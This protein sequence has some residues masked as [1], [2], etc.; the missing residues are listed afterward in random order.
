[1]AKFKLCPDCQK[2]Y[3]EP[4]NRRFH[5]QPNACIKCGPKL[6]LIDNKGNIID[7]K[8]PIASVCSLIKKGKIIGIKSLGGFQI[9]CNA[10]D[11]RVVN[12]LRK[13]KNRPSKPFALMFKNVS[14]IKK[15]LI[16]N[17]KEEQSLTSPASPIVLLLKN[18]SKTG[19]QYL[20]N[21][22]ISFHISFY[23]KYEGAL[24]P[25]TPIHYI[26]FKNLDIPLVMTSG[27]I[28]EEPIASDNKEAIEKLSFICDYFLIHNRDI[29]SKYDDSVIKIFDGKEM[30]I[31]RARGYAPYPVKLDIDIGNR[32]ILSVGAQE[33]N[34]FCLL[35]KNYAILSQHIGD[36]DSQESFKFFNST[37]NNYRKLFGIEKIDIVAYDRHPGYISTRFAKKH[38]HK[39][40]KVEIQHHKAHIAGVIAEN[41]LLKKI[42][43]SRKILG[44]AWDGTG[45]GDDGKIWGSEIFTVDSLLSFTRV[46][47]LQEKFLPGGEISIKKPYRM[48][49]VYLYKLWSEN[50]KIQKSYLNITDNYSNIKDKKQQDRNAKRNKNKKFI[51][52]SEFVFKSLPFYKKIFSIAEI[53]IV[54]KQISTG[55]NSP[56]TTSMGRFFDA[57]SSLLNLTHIS[58]YEGEAA[59]H[60]EMIADSRCEQS[61]NIRFLREFNHKINNNYYEFNKNKNNLKLKDLEYPEEF[62]FTI[63]DYYIYSQILEDLKDNKQISYISAKFHNTLADII[64]YTSLI[65]R[66][67]QKINTIILSGGVFQNNLLLL[68]SFK[69][70][71][72]NKFKVFSNFKVPVNDG[73]IS[74]GQTYFA[75]YSFQNNLKK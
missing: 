56:F 23:N 34:T 48:G 28:S 52:F 43:N 75:A 51:S 14:T 39:V 57:V 8:N 53:E 2:E 27:N 54:Q 73:G 7:K 71:K 66:K 38:F 16:I 35:T 49:L 11:D 40:E 25:Y 9:A 36:L 33:K 70:L 18:N 44:F 74:L 45:F 29:Y 19:R 12:E 13:R 72:E 22:I 63:D 64:L 58:T 60:L 61:Y 24:L 31:R 47:H 69:I 17:K 15:Y 42:K 37:L 6:L 55:F 62:Y 59:V 21:N 67:I 30:I 10:T 32:V 26:L 65:F 4:L 1:M 50:N 41:G 20:K 5:A 46:G 68:R 3:D